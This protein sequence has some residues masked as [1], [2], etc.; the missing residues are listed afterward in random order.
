M[1]PELEELLRDT[2]E[3]C[4]PPVCSLTQERPLTS[5]A[6]RITV[7]AANETEVN[8]EDFVD[9]LQAVVEGLLPWLKDDISFSES[10][11]LRTP[12]PDAHEKQNNSFP[13]REPLRIAY[14]SYLTM[15]QRMAVIEEQFKACDDLDLLL[16]TDIFR[17]H[18]GPAQA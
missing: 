8:M 1:D 11:N 7:E 17:P 18:P 16:P 2:P 3:T 9:A 4:T 5:G 10:T 13:E 15:R 14:Q 12:S 6:A